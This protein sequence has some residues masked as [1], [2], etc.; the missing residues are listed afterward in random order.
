MQARKKCLLINTS[1]LTNAYYNNEFI[2]LDINVCDLYAPCHQNCT[3]TDGG[4]TC[5]CDEGYS[6]AV[7]KVNCERMYSHCVKMLDTAIRGIF[8]V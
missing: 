7:D 5:S 8:L 2:F 3:N 1:I 4:F 6:L